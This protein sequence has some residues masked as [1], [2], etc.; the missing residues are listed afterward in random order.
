MFQGV[1]HAMEVTI[2]AMVECN[3][4][5]DRDFHGRPEGKGAT[6]AMSIAPRTFYPFPISLL[7]TVA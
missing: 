4:P 3:G 1:G 7:V 2:H 6:F 5:P